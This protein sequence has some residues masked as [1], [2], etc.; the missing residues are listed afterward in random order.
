MQPNKG[1]HAHIL[2]KYYLNLYRDVSTVVSETN[3]GE[4]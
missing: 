4:W 1:R 3:K 2:A